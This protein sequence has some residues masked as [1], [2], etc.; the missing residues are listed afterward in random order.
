MERL[1]VQVMISW[2]KWDLKKNKVKESRKD[3]LS[4][5]SFNMEMV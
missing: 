5:S 3:L 4:E 1:E 2:P